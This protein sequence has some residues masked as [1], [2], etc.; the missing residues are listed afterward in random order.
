VPA[1]RPQLEQWLRAYE[2]A[3]RSPGTDALA[4]LFTDDAG[5]RMSPYEERHAGLDAIAE[6][7]EREREGPDEEFDMTSEIV[8]VEG[9]TGVVRVHVRYHR[10][11]PQEYRDL[12][13]VRFAPDGRCAEFEEWPFWP[14]GP[15]A[16]P[17]AS[18]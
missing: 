6:L 11:P 1:G 18:G 7:W 5:Y 10:A 9:D 2:A 16:T 3:W 17:A 14:E 13:I 12:W 8:A 4:G 15:G